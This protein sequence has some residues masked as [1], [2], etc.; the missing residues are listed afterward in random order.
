M[1]V[2][3][4]ASRGDLADARNTLEQFHIPTVPT[5]PKPSKQALLNQVGLIV[6][7]SQTV[8][9]DGRRIY[10]AANT[11]LVYRTLH[12]TSGGTD[13]ATIIRARFAVEIVDQVNTVQFNIEVDAASYA[14]GGVAVRGI[15]TDS[16]DLNTA[17][18]TGFALSDDGGGL[19]SFGPWSPT[20]SKT[21]YGFE[22]QLTPV[23]ST[24]DATL[25]DEFFAIEDMTMVQNSISLLDSQESLSGATWAQHV[26]AATGTS[27]LTQTL[28]SAATNDVFITHHQLMTGKIYNFAWASPAGS[29]SNSGTEFDE[30]DLA[31]LATKFSTG[32]V[33]YGLLKD[34]TYTYSGVKPR[35][36]FTV[37]A[38]R[39]HI[40][41]P[42]GSAVLDGSVTKL[43]SGMSAVD[44]HY[45]IAYAETNNWNVTAIAAGSATPAVV[46]ATRN[47][48]LT[49][50]ASQELCNS[51]DWSYFWDNSGKEMHVRFDG[52]N[53]D[54]IIIP[55]FGGIVTASNVDYFALVNFTA[56]GF[57]AWFLD[58]DDVGFYETFNTGTVDKASGGGNGSLNVY[59][60][61]DS[62]GVHTD[63]YVAKSANDGFN[64][65]TTGNVD[66]Y[67]CTSVHN[68]DDGVS[69]HDACTGFMQGGTYDSNGKAGVIPAFG[70]SVVCVGVTAS[71]NVDGDSSLA[72][73]F[74]YG[75]FVAISNDSD[76]AQTSLVC[77]RCIAASNYFN[78]LST[79]D[80]SKLVSIEHT[81]STPNQNDFASQGWGSSPLGGTLVIVTDS[82]DVRALDS[83]DVHTY[84][85]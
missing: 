54:D 84:T 10:G 79:G 76:S 77:Y 39:S 20:G 14:A 85:V 82:T 59:T 31:T 64:I 9:G 67:D 71:S 6:Q 29:S 69:H 5:R 78:F 15:A 52:T 55:E 74:N 1:T 22:V 44:A 36:L 21:Y 30:W 72:Q 62:S 8:V 2:R 49:G 34:G 41:C 80:M 33:A 65:T 17:S 57:Y 28:P 4:P 24:D 48:T 35:D 63:D 56:K 13:G 3:H 43:F 40:V 45:K 73:D 32:S 42:A 16:A 37:T 83:D 53:T 19:F 23:D 66:L 27:F 60:I 11:D 46:L 26:L 7:Q 38:A 75:G 47:E 61:D 70:A 81:A 51:T 25:H 58:A 50:V 68:A 18:I 12:N